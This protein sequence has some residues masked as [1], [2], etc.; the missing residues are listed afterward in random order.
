MNDLSRERLEQLVDGNEETRGQLLDKL[1]YEDVDKE[2]KNTIVELFNGHHSWYPARQFRIALD[3]D[4]RRL[5]AKYFPDVVKTETMQERYRYLVE[6]ESEEEKGMRVEREPNRP[7]RRQV[8]RTTGR[9]G[10]GPGI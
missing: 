4:K 7:G 1:L 6:G 2:C 8:G 10:R 5:I 9:T 3:E